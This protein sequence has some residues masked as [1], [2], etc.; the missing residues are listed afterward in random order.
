MTSLSQA[1]SPRALVRNV[2]Q[3]FAG[4]PTFEQA[5]HDMLE[6]A[7]KARYPSLTLDLSKTQLACPG[8]DTPTW[9]FQP[10]SPMVL[11]YLA[12]G[13]PVDLGS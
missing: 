4:R 12:H 10:F 6:Q 11:D 3:Q 7:I 2:S 9:R 8:T 1:D 5:V 13:T